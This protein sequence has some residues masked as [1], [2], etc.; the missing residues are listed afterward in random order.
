MN[1]TGAINDLLGQ[2]HNPASSNHYSYLEIVLIDLRDFEKWG[3]TEK[4]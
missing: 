4:L 1:K 3:R 2:I